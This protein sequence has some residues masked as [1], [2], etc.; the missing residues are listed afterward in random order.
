MQIN[1]TVVGSTVGEL[2][3]VVC[4]SQPVETPIHCN[5]VVE[6]VMS[7]VF[8]Q[9][10]SVWALSL[11]AVWP[12]SGSGPCCA[13]VSS[14]RKEDTR[15]NGAQSRERLRVVTG[16]ISWVEKGDSSRALGS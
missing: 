3:M 11:A 1:P 2:W 8:T 6:N 16:E 5:E 12:C 15:N 9:E 10:A 7:E 4:T 13:L 14:P